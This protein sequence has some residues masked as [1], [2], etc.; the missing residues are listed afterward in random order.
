[1]Q[2]KKP[3]T[4]Q[5]EA[6]ISKQSTQQL[7][8]FPTSSTA[9]QMALTAS[10]LWL[11]DWDLITGKMY[12]D[13]L[14]KKTLGYEL[15]PV[16][17][18]YTSFEQ[19]VNPE[20][21]P[22]IQNLLNDYLQGR[23]PI[24]Q[25][26]FRMLTKSGDW[27]WILARGQVSQWD[28]Q[29]KPLR[30]T[31]TYEDIS[32]KIAHRHHTEA[33]LKE[34][35]QQLET[36]LAELKNCQKQLLQTQKMANLGNML[37]NI[38]ND[39]YN[40]VNFIHGTLYPVSQY[41]EN[42]VGLIEA[43]QYYYPK[44]PAEMVEQIERLN[45]NFVKTD[46]LQLL[47]SMRSGC[48]RVQGIVSALQNFSCYAHGQI[49]KFDIHEGIGS[50][51]KILQHRLKEQPN[52]PKIEINTQFGK[53]PLVDCFPSELNQVFLNIFTNAIDALEERTKHDY[54]LIPKIW[55]STEVAPN[56]LALVTDKNSPKK[57]RIIIRILDNGQGMLPH[58]QR[59]IFE[60]FFTT[61]SANEHKGLGLSISQQIIVEKYQGKLKSSSRFGE[62]AEFVI[63]IK[64]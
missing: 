37:S 6:E 58:I 43:Y 47:W 17:N 49:A 34:K 61:K 23:I 62:G 60:P 10:G 33:L 52:R 31:G 28:E 59:R 39:I 24:Y 11:W 4:Q 55:I 56:H 19:L 36:T 18:H 63:E 40:P 20:D 12:Y 44:P 14:C 15:E 30:M 3:A 25:A 48:D 41:A 57:Q 8:E 5:L 46:F 13:P 1:M 21:L 45:L 7:L 2:I 51:T 22:Q 29:R 16:D 9:L 53:L 64:V 50:V 42:L 35:S 32:E 54:S 38:S 27:K 26:E